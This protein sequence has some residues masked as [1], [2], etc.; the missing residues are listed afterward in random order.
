MLKRPDGDP[1]TRSHRVPGRA[2]HRAPGDARIAVVWWSPEPDALALG[3]QAPSGLRR[4]DLIVKD[5]PAAV[6]A[7]H[8]HTYTTWQAIAPGCRQRG[9]APC[10]AV[11]TAT[12]A[13]A[14][15]RRPALEDV[16]ERSRLA[17]GTSREAEAGRS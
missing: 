3:A 9:R 14:G 6:V 2:P 11:I 5:V 8:L 4:D 12:E 1:A 10:G 17:D 7:E 13:A 16:E 15:G